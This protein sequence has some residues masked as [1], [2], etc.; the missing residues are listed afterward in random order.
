MLRFAPPIAPFREN[1]GQGVA[2]DPSEVIKICFYRGQG[3]SLREIASLVDRSKSAVGTVLQHCRHLWETGMD[4]PAANP[5]RYS[6]Y[7]A[8]ERWLLRHYLL[9]V[10]A[11]DPTLSVRRIAEMLQERDFPF[12]AG[13][14]KINDELMHMS[15]RSGRPILRPRLTDDQRSYRETF[16][17]GIQTDL[18]MFLPWMFS[19]ETMITRNNKN[20]SV[21]RIPTLI[22]PEQSDAK[23]ELHPIRIMAWG[24]SRKIS[25]L[26]LCEYL[27]IST[28]NN[29]RR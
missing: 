15:I 9:Y 25:S 18:K 5:I 20:Y 13:K 2:L 19:D 3:R 16:A 27:V 6:G 22:V 4:F 29:I 24:Q 7:A 10:L 21:R 28:L 23:M 8:P 14:S 12:K 1:R 26:P 11:E 17:V